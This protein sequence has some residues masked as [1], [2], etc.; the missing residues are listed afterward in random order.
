VILAIPKVEVLLTFNVPPTV[1]EARVTVPVA[2]RLPVVNA[3]EEAR[4][5]LVLPVTV[6]VPVTDRVPPIVS[7]PKIVEVPIYDEVAYRLVAVMLI[8]NMSRNLVAYVPRE[9]VPA[10]VGS[11]LAARFNRPFM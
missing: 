4:A 7:L 1:V 11:I 2:Y 10:V 3:V 6:V 5:R 9:Y 8:P